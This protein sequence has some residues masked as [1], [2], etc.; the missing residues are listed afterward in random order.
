M[1]SDVA[2]TNKEAPAYKGQVYFSKYVMF[3]GYLKTT[4]FVRFAAVL[5]YAVGY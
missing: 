5:R 3:L 1:A 2:N 4:S